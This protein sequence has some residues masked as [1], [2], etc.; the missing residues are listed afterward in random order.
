MSFDLRVVG[1]DLAIGTNS[2][3]STIENS[4]KLI[5][6]VLK[7]VL[8]PIGSNPFFPWYGSP[9]TKSLLGTAF[10][11]KFVSA[12]AS[13]QLRTALE[14]LQNLQ[15]EQ[16]KQSQVVTPQE[17]IAAV[18]NVIIERNVLDPRFFSV[19]LTVLNKAFRRAQTAF[20]VDAS[21]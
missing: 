17:Q 13:N 7:I 9:I 18:Q 6:D 16:L 19:R 11:E 4:E 21:L 5:Q 14:T 8:T 15:R 1:R 3:L 12:V 20:T 2:D 10:E